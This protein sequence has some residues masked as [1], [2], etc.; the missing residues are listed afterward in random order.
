MGQ[1]VLI[2][3]REKSFGEVEVIPGIDL[4][5]TTA[6]SSSSSALGLRQVHAAAPDRRA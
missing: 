5:S 1:I 2:Q 3:L 6:N 4:E